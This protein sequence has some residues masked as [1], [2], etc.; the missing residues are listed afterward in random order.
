MEGKG[1]QESRLTI[2]SHLFQA[3]DQYIP[4]TKKLGKGGRKPE[5]ISKE[6]IKWKK[7]VYG[8]WKR[9]LAT[10]EEY[11]NTVS[12]TCRDAIRK[13]KAHLEL[14]LAREVKERC[15]YDV[16]SCSTS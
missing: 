3:Q 12:N 4:K 11:R 7:K 2:K 16:R 1:V 14:D 6:K 15:W 5:W 8:M 13:A 9:G 10:L